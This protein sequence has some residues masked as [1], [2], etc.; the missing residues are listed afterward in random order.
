[1]AQ[2]Q[3]CITRSLIHSYTFGNCEFCENPYVM[4]QCQLCMALCCTIIAHLAFHTMPNVQYIIC[5]TILHIW[6]LRVL[7]KPVCNGTMPN[8]HDIVVYI[9]LHKWHFAKY[10][11]DHQMIIRWSL[12]DHQ[13]I[14][15]L[16]SYDHK[17]II[18]WYNIIDIQMII[19]WTLDDNRWSSVDHH[20]T[21]TWS[22][23][24]LIR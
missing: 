11:L 14:I 9:K 15:S 23:Y 1:M 2:C 18:I 12:D 13:M 3:I 24:D 6:H 20:M 22:S 19:I 7:R 16:S 17:F 4:A 10:D 8:M 21:I 5:Y